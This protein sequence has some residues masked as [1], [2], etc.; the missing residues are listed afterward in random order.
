M[1][2]QSNSIL[3]AVAGL[4]IATGNAAMIQVTGYDSDAIAE[5]GAD[6][7][8]VTDNTGG[9]FSNF[10]VIAANTFTGVDNLP[11]GTN[12]AIVGDTVTTANGTV[13]SVDPDALNT[14]MGNG[15]LTLTTPAQY[16]NLQFLFGGPGGAWSATINFSDSSTATFTPSPTM[17]DWQSGTIA[18]P[19]FAGKTAYVNEGSDLHFKNGL[20]VRELTYDLEVLDQA[21]T[22]NSITI[23]TSSNGVFGLSGTPVPEPS[24]TALLG[25]GGLALILR[26]RK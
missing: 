18:S 15:T 13:F 12:L 11:N 6:A 17:L 23:A 16:E 2:I 10:S 3:A 9:E 24:S 20:W 5:S 14:L 8:A 7:S 4:T 21:K 22:I 1:K 25:L 19:A 26:R